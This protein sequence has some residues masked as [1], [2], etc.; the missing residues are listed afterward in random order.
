MRSLHEAGGWLVTVL[1]GL[2]AAWALIALRRPSWRNKRLWQATAV[3]ET[4]VFVQVSLGVALLQQPGRKT[5]ELHTLYGFLTLATIAI[6]YAYKDQM[7][8]RLLLLYGLGGLFLVGLAIRA[9][10]VGLDR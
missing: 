2:V 6:M 1:N 7:K 9:L 5:P 3:S 8:E 10:T 4:L